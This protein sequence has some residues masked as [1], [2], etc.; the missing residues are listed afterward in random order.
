MGASSISE[1]RRVRSETH[2]SL[3]SM[4]SISLKHKEGHEDLSPTLDGIWASSFL[5]R[6]LLHIVLAYDH[7]RGHIQIS[8]FA[9]AHSKRVEDSSLNPTGVHWTCHCLDIAPYQPLIVELQYNG[10]NSSVR[11]TTKENTTCICSMCCFA[12][13]HLRLAQVT[14]CGC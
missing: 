4:C 7:T 9:P 12:S 10:N 1:G 5:L 11:E 3:R 6:T 14:L 2:Q 8:L 13:G